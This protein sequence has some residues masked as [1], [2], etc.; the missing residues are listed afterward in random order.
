LGRTQHERRQSSVLQG[1][2]IET[3]DS[4]RLTVG[5]GFNRIFIV[6]AVMWA[7]Y[8][9]FVYPLQTRN[10]LINFDLKMGAF[11]YDT[12]NA[13]V[14]KDCTKRWVDAADKDGKEWT[15][16]NYYKTQ[17]ELIL[18]ATTVVP[19]FVYGLCR[20]VVFVFGWIYRGFKQPA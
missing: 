6:L 12:T 5:R 19:A 2:K 9:L 14:R 7:F 10:S 20:F 13:E 11:C 4:K 1:F 15:L 8:C 3:M 18:V 16:A 17:W